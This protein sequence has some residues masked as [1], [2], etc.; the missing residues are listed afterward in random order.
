MSA[1]HPYTLQH[2]IQCSHTFCPS[3]HARQLLRLDATGGQGD[4]L[5][6]APAHPEAVDGEGSKVV[7]EEGHGGVQQVVLQ[8]PHQVGPRVNHIDK[9]ALEELVPICSQEF[10]TS[11]AGLFPGGNPHAGKE[12]Q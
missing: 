7:A 1:T 11:D 4:D 6:A 10:P 3:R 8:E 2:D 9:L 12:L 5:H